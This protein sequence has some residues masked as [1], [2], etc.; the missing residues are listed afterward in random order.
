MLLTTSLMKKIVSAL[1]RYNRKG[2]IDPILMS[3]FNQRGRWFG[4]P[5]VD[6]GD[7]AAKI[8]NERIPK[9]VLIMDDGEVLMASFITQSTKT[10]EIPYVRIW[11]GIH[12]PNAAAVIAPQLTEVLGSIDVGNAKSFDAPNLSDV[13]GSLNALR[14]VD[15]SAPLRRVGLFPDHPGN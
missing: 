8:S 2:L 10:V 5:G 14:A 3:C 12:A 15:F 11:G 9:S 13:G 7:L 6:F 1:R 4:F